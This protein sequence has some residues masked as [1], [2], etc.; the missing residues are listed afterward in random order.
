MA[1]NKQFNKYN[2]VKKRYTMKGQR[3]QNS[4]F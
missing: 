2:P 3:A 4:F 1:I